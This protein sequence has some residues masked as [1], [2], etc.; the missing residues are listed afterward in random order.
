[1]LCFSKIVEIKETMNVS[2]FNIK[3]GILHVSVDVGGRRQVSIITVSLTTDNPR[4][5]TALFF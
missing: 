3:K 5:T 1:M 2:I 4:H